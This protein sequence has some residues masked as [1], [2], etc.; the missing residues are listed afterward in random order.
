MVD[1]GGLTVEFFNDDASQTALDTDL[2]LDDQTAFNFAV[3][4]SEDVTKANVYPIKYRVY[5]TNYNSNV[6]TLADPFVI[7]VIDPCDKPTS[8]TAPA[9]DA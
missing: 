1:C 2:F 6:V 3:Q 7:T 4:Y 9:L 8:I 5:H